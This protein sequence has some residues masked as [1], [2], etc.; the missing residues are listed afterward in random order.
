MA[1]KKRLGRGLDALL[2][3][4]NQTAT[5][6]YSAGSYDDMS[7]IDLAPGPY[8]PRQSID[9]DS[10]ADLVQSIQQ[11]GVLQPLLV[12]AKSG[13]MAKDKLAKY[14]IVAGER[15]WRAAKLAG[16]KSV[17]VIIRDLDDK[18]ALAVALI[19]NLQRE[20]L[21]PIEV[22]E[23]LHKLVEEFGLTHKEVAEAVGRSRSAV[24]NY[25]RLLD[26]EPSVRN[27]LTTAQLDMG[28]ARALLSLDDREQAIVANKVAKEDLSV[29]QVE[30]LVADRMNSDRARA[31]KPV[32]SIDT[33]SRWLQHQ[34][35]KELGVN[36]AIRV[37]K[38]GGRTLGIEFNDLEQ[39]QTTLVEITELVQQVR[40]TAGPRVRD[41]KR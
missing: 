15:R 8:Q 13:A 30:S 5:P 25:L 14:E 26:L 12:R 37:R 28:H 32:A 34:F 41:S 29:R 1:T 10:L 24:S 18:A 2:S 27:L 11:Q 17:P 31:A 6:A 23:S 19:E 9:D 22:A 20:D 16:F 40:D 35:A 36:V 4:G 33:Q 3:G 7:I 38:N 39:L 21:S